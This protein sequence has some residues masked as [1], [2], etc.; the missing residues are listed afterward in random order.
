[1]KQSCYMKSKL[2]DTKYLTHRDIFE[3]LEVLY[4]KDRQYREYLEHIV[5]DNPLWEVWVRKQYFE[6]KNGRRLRSDGTLCPW[7]MQIINRRLNKDVIILMET[8]EEADKLANYTD[9]QMLKVWYNEY[10]GNSYDKTEGEDYE[11][12]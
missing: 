6:Y 5:Q 4:N 11:I 8:R 3:G 10:V 1:M 7:R 9:E 2:R 12:Q